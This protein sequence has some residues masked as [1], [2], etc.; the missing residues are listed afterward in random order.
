MSKAF[1]CKVK[2]VFTYYK[3]HFVALA[4]TDQILEYYSVR[5]KVESDFNELK[6]DIG[7]QK[8]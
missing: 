2:M 6:Y 1:K 7:S 5:W 3:S 4:T 8:S